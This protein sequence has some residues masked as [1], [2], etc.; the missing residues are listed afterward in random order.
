[1]TSD[2]FELDPRLAAGTLALGDLTLCRVL[3]MDD[4]RFP[5]LVLVPR[6]AGASEILDLG[7]G[8]R[9]RL[10]DEIATAAQALREAA[11]CDKLNIGALGNLVPQLHVHILARRR[12]DDAWP[13][14]AWGFGEP[15][16]YRPERRAALAAD[17]AGR[18][19]IAGR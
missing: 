2:T 8:D 12:G 19:G 14:P 16:R 4:T 13:G 10:M 7:A 6:Q 17:L 15:I 1:M 11:P 3:L 18:L 9:A 5:W